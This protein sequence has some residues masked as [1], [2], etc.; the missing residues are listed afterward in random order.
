MKRIG[1]WLLL[2]LFCLL[3]MGC[4]AVESS[5]EPVV[6][7]DEI[8]ILDGSW[9]DEHENYLILNAAENRYVFVTR[10]GRVGGGIYRPLSESP[11]LL[12]CGASFRLTQD[13]GGI[14]FSCEGMQGEEG[15]PGGLF[16]RSSKRY[17]EIPAADLSGTWVSSSGNA[18]T[19]DGENMTYRYSAQNGEIKG[20]LQDAQDGRGWFL[21]TENGK[22]FLSVARDKNAL[23][24]LERFLTGT[25]EETFTRQ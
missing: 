6:P 5:P 3:P 16:Y 15:L 12:F 2:C 13:E 19:L 7:S 4:S 1:L 9:V 25:A 8:R 22:V 17:Y 18:L 11:V 21:S 10:S 24:L 14:S 23:V 20:D